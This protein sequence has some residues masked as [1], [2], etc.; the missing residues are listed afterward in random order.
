MGSEEGNE[1]TGQEAPESQGAER[2]LATRFATEWSVDCVSDQTFLYASIT[3]ISLFGIF[4]ATNTP[5]EVGSLV[6]LR[7][8]PF[9]ITPF[10]LPGRVQWVNRS[11]ALRRSKNEGMGIQFVSLSP[12]DRERLV[13]AIH[14]IAYLRDGMN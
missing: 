10:S 5:F 3:N 8:A 2:R 9:G 13:E 11:S 4:V 14:T 1:E 12:E 6:E 7:F